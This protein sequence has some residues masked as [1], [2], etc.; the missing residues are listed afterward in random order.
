MGYSFYK[1]EVISVPIS[2]QVGGNPEYTSY[3]N[4][5]LGTYHA[6][7]FISYT[8]TDRYFV[9]FLPKSFSNKKVHHNV[10]LVVLIPGTDESALTSQLTVQNNNNHPEI[11]WQQLSHQDTFIIVILQA[12]ADKNFYK[13]RYCFDMGDE[14]LVYTDR[15]LSYVTTN[16][17]I[18]SSSIY[19]CGFSVGGL[20]I[21]SLAIYRSHHFSA[22]CN[23]MGG[24]SDLPT[25]LTDP[26]LRKE[27]EQKIPKIIHAKE[28]IPIWIITASGEDN[29]RYC[30]RAK[31]EFES[32]GWSVTWRDIP[33]QDHHYLS[34]QTGDIWNWMKQFK[35]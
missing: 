34:N 6:Y 25:Y 9:V 10:P 2:P 12:K 15:V 33:D 23:Y 7:K 14:D 5:D 11:T 26:V 13:D 32:N 16:Y 20:F 28:K 1:E 31:A 21:S 35:K 3:I 27:L 4:E 30:L 19:G 17:P 8:G 22:L 18:D 24:L 29:R